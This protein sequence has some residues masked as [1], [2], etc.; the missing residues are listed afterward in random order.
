LAIIV[1][2]MYYKKF[3]CAQPCRYWELVVDIPGER[4]K[5]GPRSARAWTV[6]IDMGRAVAIDEV[7]IEPPLGPI[8]LFERG[9]L[10][11]PLWARMD[12]SYERRQSKE[13]GNK[14]LAQAFLMPDEVWAHPA[15]IIE[16]FDYLFAIDTNTKNGISVAGVVSGR[17][18][19][20]Q[21][22]GKTAVYLP[23]LD[24]C[25]EF[26]GMQG[27]AENIAWVQV[28][29]AIRRNRTYRP[30]FQIGIVVDS[31]LENLDRYNYRALPVFGDF[32]LPANMTFIYASSER[33]GETYMNMMIALAD[34]EARR[35]LDYI[36]REGRDEGLRQ[37]VN[38]P[39]TYF[40]QWD[41]S[42]LPPRTN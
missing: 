18:F 14:V 40:R 2:G 1:P 34:K 8:R 15:R 24:F 30:D 11:E 10:V 26:R 38:E 22:P 28:I 17:A 31:D 41:P 21:I 6:S 13:K 35:V 39:F 23:N 5:H 42:A 25:A 4:S 16:C 7:M 27:K 20:V 12:V 3:D 37:P 19:K 9:V 32:Y 29:Q 33:P 36:L